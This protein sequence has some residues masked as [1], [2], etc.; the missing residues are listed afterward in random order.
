MKE[1]T[2]P[3][4]R[5]IAS[6]GISAQNRTFKASCSVRSGNSRRTRRASHAAPIILEGPTTNATLEYTNLMS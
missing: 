5:T 4:L 6:A 2:A 3:N 1:V